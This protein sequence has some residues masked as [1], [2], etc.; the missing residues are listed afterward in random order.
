MLELL[1]V[2][3]T[4]GALVVLSWRADARLP[5][6]ARLPMQWSLSGSVNW[7]APRRVALGFMPAFGTLVMLA[8]GASALWLPPRAGQAGQ[9]VPA[10]ALTGG[11]LVAIH[12]LHLWLMAR[13]LRRRG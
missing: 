1:I 7:T 5:P 3:L 13:S 10:L 8:A 12:A 11:A 6:A 4:V 2:T 9:V